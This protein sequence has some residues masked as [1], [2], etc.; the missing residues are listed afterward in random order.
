M[1]KLMIY[2]H[3]MVIFAVGVLCCNADNKPVKYFGAVNVL[4]TTIYAYLYAMW[5]LWQMVG[6]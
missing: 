1:E 4:W 3:L 6:K 2:V 5:S